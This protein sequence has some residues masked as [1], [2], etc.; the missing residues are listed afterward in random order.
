MSNRDY[1]R[2]RSPAERVHSRRQISISNKN[3][4]TRHQRDVDSAGFMEG[5][6]AVTLVRP[7]GRPISPRTFVKARSHNFVNLVD[8]PARN[9]TPRRSSGRNGDYANGSNCTEHSS[10][11]NYFSTVVRTFPRV[12]LFS[13]VS[14]L[15]LSALPRAFDSPRDIPAYHSERRPPARRAAGFIISPLP[16]YNLE[17]FPIVLFSRGRDTRGKK[18]GPLYLPAAPGTFDRFI[19]MKR[20]DGP[21]SGETDALAPIRA[22]MPRVDCENVR[23]SPARSLGRGSSKVALSI[24]IAIFARLGPRRAL[25]YQL[26]RSCEVC[27]ERPV[28]RRCARKR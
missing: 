27:C 20:R 9:H 13:P 25:Y 5:S 26:I 28:R 3:L 8:E 7:A 22:A 24:L 12:R 14:P 17:T 23:A 18:L 19:K 4:R 15:S 2:S 21:F 6:L 1:A 11:D 10:T 16:R